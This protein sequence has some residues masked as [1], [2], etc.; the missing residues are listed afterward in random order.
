MILERLDVAAIR[1]CEKRGMF[2]TEA[3]LAAAGFD[4]DDYQQRVHRLLAQGVIQSLSAVLVVPPLL[5]GDWVWAGVLLNVARPLGVANALVKKLPF[6]TEI[7]LNAG[8]PEKLGPNL[9]LLFYSRDFETEAQFIRS[10]SGM[11]HQ[12]VYLVAEYSFP[13]A[14]SLS[15]D[16]RALLKYLVENP[17][18]DIPAIEQALGRN[19]VWVQA[20]LDRLF[21]TETHRSGVIRIQP[22]VD[23]GRVDNFGHFH[24]LLETGY[25]PGQLAKMI[26]DEGFEIVLAGRTYRERYVQVEADIWGVAELMKRIFYL[27]HI[28][29]INVAGIVWNERM[30]V[31][32][33]WMAKLLK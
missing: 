3:E 8:L 25:K 29:G 27:N 1:L 30:T 17:A 32:S 18:S 26:V 6:V 23:W 19:R 22:Q 33:S 21:W 16:E 10:V 5:G 15:N 7:I 14:M 20:K 31:N 9:A 11:E 13:I 2:P 24:F 12:E 28:A 4:S